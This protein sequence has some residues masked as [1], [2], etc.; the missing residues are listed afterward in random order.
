[1]EKAIPA[2]NA[3]LFMLNAGLR[4]SVR[5]RQFTEETIHVELARKPVGDFQV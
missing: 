4:L 3:E 1:M 2:H 5:E